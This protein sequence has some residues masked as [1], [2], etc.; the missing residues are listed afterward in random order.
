[1]KLKTKIGLQFQESENSVSID[2][3]ES[4]EKEN[5]SPDDFLFSS[6][7]VGVTARNAASKNIL[8]N[9]S[10]AHIRQFVSPFFKQVNSPRNT[11]LTIEKIKINMQ[12]NEN[13]KRKKRRSSANSSG[14]TSLDSRKEKKLNSIVNRLCLPTQNIILKAIKEV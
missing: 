14:T 2:S 4:D 9:F 7:D 5:L 11:R 1:M 10:S 13:I 8:A 6:R 12:E 3:R